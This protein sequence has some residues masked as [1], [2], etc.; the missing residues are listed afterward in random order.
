MLPKH[1]LE[2][3]VL[4]STKS[5]GYCQNTRIRKLCISQRQEKS[6]PNKASHGLRGFFPLFSLHLEASNDVVMA[7]M[8]C[9]DADGDFT[10]K[11][12]FRRNQP[13]RNPDTSWARCVFFSTLSSPS[14]HSR[15]SIQ[16]ST[17][18]LHLSTCTLSVY[19]ALLQSLQDS[20]DLGFIVLLLSCRRK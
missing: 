14:T 20:E 16:T 7:V 5:Y 6:A 17:A 8:K 12:S 13:I 9:D 4:S 11:Q 10:G 2:I 15:G 1:N 18:F 3:T 19:G